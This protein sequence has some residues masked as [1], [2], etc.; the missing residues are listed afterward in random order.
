MTPSPLTN[1]SQPATES[2][3]GT[4]HPTNRTKSFSVGDQTQ[5]TSVVDSFSPLPD[6]MLQLLRVSWILRLV[7]CRH[8]F[9]L[10]VGLTNQSETVIAPPQ[11]IPMVTRGA[12]ALE[13]LILR[14]IT[15]THSAMNGGPM[16]ILAFK[17][18][19]DRKQKHLYG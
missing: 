10:P 19:Y 15:D 12:P 5:A 6:F 17:Q 14:V 3:L 2:G 1:T 8:Q 7:P 11:P 9:P 4:I 18:S 13:T 16:M